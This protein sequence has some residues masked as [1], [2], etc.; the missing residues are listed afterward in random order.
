VF[1]TAIVCLVLMVLLYWS[2]RGSLASRERALELAQ[3]AGFNEQLVLE[4]LAFRGYPFRSPARVHA[5]RR[6]KK[7]RYATRGLSEQDGVIIC[8][9]CNA[10]IE[11][12]RKGLIFAIIVMM[13]P[14]AV[15]AY[16]YYYQAPEVSFAA[17]AA[18]VV[19]A[20]A[21]SGHFSK[22]T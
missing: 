5:V 19:A 10:P 16:G 15:A 9:H 14:P 7:C 20:G 2:Y 21:L 11:R 4:Q 8:R 13:I 18:L 12:P 22:V 17:V 6:C 1:A 3:I